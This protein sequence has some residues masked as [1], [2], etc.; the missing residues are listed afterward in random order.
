MKQ[1]ELNIY[2]FKKGDVITRLK[3]IVDE[4]GQKD[5]TFIGRKVTFLGIANASVYL[6]RDMDFLASLFTG[7]TKQT[8]QLPVEMWEDGWAYYV[9]PDFLDEDS[10]LFGLDEEESLK[11][12]IDDAA[13]ADDY[14]KADRLL[15]RLEDLKR[16]KDK[17]KGKRG[18]K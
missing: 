8:I 7:M 18:D 14:E 2:N 10:P 16:G 1:E 17:G 4:D 13:K 5:Y 6:S 12:Q 15:K 3:P 11:Q 9:E